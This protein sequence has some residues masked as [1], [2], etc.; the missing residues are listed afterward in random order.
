MHV[1]PRLRPEA[2]RDDGVVPATIEMTIRGWLLCRSFE[3]GQHPELAR[4]KMISMLMLGHTIGTS[5]NLLKTGLIF[6]M[7]PLTFN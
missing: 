7:N 1:H 5:G 6:G 3:G 2:F 4:V